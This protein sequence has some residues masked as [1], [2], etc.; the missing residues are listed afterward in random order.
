MAAG[1]VNP[2]ARTADPEHAMRLPDIFRNPPGK[3]VPRHRLEGLITPA[4]AAKRHQVPAPQPQVCH[5]LAELVAGA[6]VCLAAL[7]LYQ[8]PDMARL[9]MQ[10]MK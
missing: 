10:V 9:A 2:L 7:W 4:A 6:V 1:P 5:H 8:L 3:L